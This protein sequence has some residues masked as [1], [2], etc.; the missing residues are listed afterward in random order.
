M[1]CGVVGEEMEVYGDQAAAASHHFASSLGRSQVGNHATSNTKCKVSW[2]LINFLQLLFRILL[3]TR[4]VCNS[5]Y[6]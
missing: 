3:S 6:R 2:R 5:S 1:E 4:T